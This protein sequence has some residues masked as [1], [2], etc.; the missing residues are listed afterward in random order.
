MLAGQ[1]VTVEVHGWQTDD[2][3][4]DYTVVLPELPNELTPAEAGALA[5]ALTEAAAHTTSR[6]HGGV[7]GK[8]GCTDPVTLCSGS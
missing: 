5:A 4:I 3:R 8:P 2:G 6:Q 7:G 1:P